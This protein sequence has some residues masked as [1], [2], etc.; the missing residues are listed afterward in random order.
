MYEL[1]ADY[2][3]GWDPEVP[4]L[5]IVRQRDIQAGDNNMC[6]SS[7]S[8]D[9]GVVEERLTELPAIWQAMGDVLQ[10]NAVRAISG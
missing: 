3:Y 9:D 6:G 5:R 10:N 2:D 1:M 4:E 8:E 7:R